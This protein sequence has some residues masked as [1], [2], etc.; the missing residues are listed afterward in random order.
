MEMLIPWSVSNNLLTKCHILNLC[1]SVIEL[2]DRVQ[3]FFRVKNVYVIKT[4]A[5]GY[6]ACLIRWLELLSRR[7]RNLL[8]ISIS[9]VLC[10]YHVNVGSLTYLRHVLGLHADVRVCLC[11]F[12]ASAHLVCSF[13]CKAKQGLFEWLRYVLSWLYP[14]RK[15]QRFFDFADSLICKLSKSLTL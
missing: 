8:C 6:D 2:R 10:E 9:L 15:T 5:R 1:Y 14:L 12:A 11:G 4:T 13:S 7:L 3:E